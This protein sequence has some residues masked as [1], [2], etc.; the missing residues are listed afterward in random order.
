[1]SKIIWDAVGEHTYETGVDHGVLYQLATTGANKGKYTDGVAWNGLTSVSESPSGAEAQKQYADNMNYLTL[2]SAE[3]FG[4]TIEAFT[5]PPEFE[6][7]DGSA[8]VS[9]VNIAQ[10]SRKSFGLCYRTKVGNDVA[11]DD[12]GYKLHL[13][14]GCRASPS[15]RGYSTINDSPEAITFSWEIST[16]PVQL[17]GYEPTALLTIDTTKLTEEESARLGLLEKVLFGQNAD[18]SANPA[19]EATVPTLPLPAVVIG[20]MDGSI[21]TVAEALAA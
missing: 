6:Q 16:T 2:Y 15:E 13:V 14:Y 3:E 11:G 7:N 18:S 12:F 9:G 17:T 8:S 20:I 5:Y 19:V 4:A 1:M 21:E 10:Q